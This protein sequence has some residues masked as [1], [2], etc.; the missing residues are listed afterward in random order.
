[1]TDDFWF[2]LTNLDHTRFRGGGGRGRYS[3]TQVKLKWIGF[4]KK[5]TKFD[6]LRFC[7]GQA[8]VSAF[9]APFVHL[10]GDVALMALVSTHMVKERFV[11][12]SPF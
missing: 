11:A 8:V 3:R 5:I 2:S 10:S 12:F 6:Y 1:M 7:F 9:Q 4:H